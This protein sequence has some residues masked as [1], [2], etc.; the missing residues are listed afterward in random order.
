[1]N[2]SGSE[3]NAEGG[4]AGL[5]DHYE[6]W[7]QQI[8]TD[9]RATSLNRLVLSL[10]PMGKV[11]DIG[12][13][14]GALSA[15]LLRAGRNVISQDLSERMVA[16]CRNYLD[17][18]GLDNSRV[19]HGSIDDIPEKQHFD[20][21]ISLD[22]IEH[23]EDDMK[24]VEK[25]RATLKPG[26]TLVLSVPAM[27]V[28]YGPKDVEVGHYRRYDKQQLID[29]LSSGGFDIQSCRFWNVLGVLPVWISV[30]RGKRLDE[31]MRYGQSVSK[32]A[33]NAALRTWFRVVENPLSPP[34]GLTL[35]VTARPRRALFS[36]TQRPVPPSPPGTL[37]RSISRKA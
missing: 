31:S 8:E 1:M 7:F 16:M 14:S 23:I 29:V 35:L 13:G 20:A 37:T 33:L 12:C 22:V 9:F 36:A 19:R 26:G 15:E 5:E 3:F 4:R 28:L 25:M 30:L 18:Q 10:T 21:V 6:K 17:R 27:S 2:V 34:L 24:A 32:R 11:L